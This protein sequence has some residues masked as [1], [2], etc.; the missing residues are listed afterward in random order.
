MAKPVA[1]FAKTILNGTG[2]K[3]ILKPNDDGYY[4]ITLGAFDA[5]NE[6]GILYPYNQY[7]KSQFQANSD[8]M[9]RMANGNLR[10][11]VEHPAMLPGMRPRDYLNRLRQIDLRNVCS[12]IS[13][14][15]IVEDKDENGRKIYRVDGLVKPSGIH[16]LALLESF[17]SR[18]ENTCFSLRSIVFQHFKGEQVNRDVRTLVTWDHVGEPGK[19]MAHKFASPGLENY[20]DGL[21]ITPEL[22]AQADAAMQSMPMAAGLESSGLTTSMIK[23]DLGWQNVQLV[24]PSATDW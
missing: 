15:M 9:R 13:K 14:L 22:L 8:L 2:K 5:F 18:E 17:D 4:L 12:H 6:S 1:T 3:G 16:K 11:E 20:S 21:D 23:N 10:S 7:L 24:R 19:R